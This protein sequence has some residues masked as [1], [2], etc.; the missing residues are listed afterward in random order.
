MKLLTLKALYHPGN[1]IGIGW[2]NLKLNK[3][4]TKE[5]F[6]LAEVLI[7][8]GIVGVVAA[9]TLPALIVNVKEKIK[10]ARVENIEQK[11]TQATDKMYTLDL[12]APYSS[13]EEFVSEL[14]KHLKIAKVCTSDN[15]RACWPYDKIMLLNGTEYNVSDIKTGAAFLM[16]NDD[17]NDYTTNNVGIV[18]ADGAAWILSY[19]TKCALTDSSKG[20]TSAGSSDSTTSC[21]SGIFD[22]N[23][24]SKPNTY[25][26]DVIAFHT[27]GLGNACTIQ[28]KNGTCYSAPFVPQPISSSEC[29][30]IKATLGIAYCGA[31]PDYWAAAVKYCGGIN[32][33]PKDTDLADIA[34][35]FYDTTSINTTQE[36]HIE[37]KGMDMAKVTSLG[38]SVSGGIFNVFSGNEVNGYNAYIRNFQSNDTNWYMGGRSDGSIQFVCIQ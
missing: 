25:T 16:N 13:T 29:N 14:Q 26:E 5:A 32:K 11:L 30:A 15:L 28:G 31:E 34:K 2:L 4:K 19:N 23:G 35:A 22:Y 9:L 18:T 12:L 20:I 27:N 38:F 33:M 17:N 10:V 21:I 37:G 7:T 24:A 6:T 36:T 8:L 1:N 3:K